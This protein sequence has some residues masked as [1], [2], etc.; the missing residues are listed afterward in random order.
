MKSSLQFHTY[1]DRLDG[2]PAAAIF[3]ALGVFTRLPFTSKLLYH[4]DSIN[5][6]LGMEH[7][8]VRL[9]QPH[10]PGYLLYVL[11]GRFLQIFFRDANTSLV[12]I[13]LIFSGLTVAVVYALAR[14]LFDLPTALIAGL[15][16][17]TS[18]AVW[19][20]G[21]VGLTYIL[22]TFF[23]T[24]IALACLQA[25]RG[26][27]RTVYVAAILLGLAGGIRQTTLVLMLPLLAFV[28]L[29]WGWRERILGA[30]ALGIAV[31]AWLI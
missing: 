17:L 21:E 3:F 30:L 8:D 2:W 29:R 25:L 6:A 10:P 23:V 12:V 4:W 7:Y 27:R 26:E 19:F 24:A 1:L 5:F 11:L 18:P 15:F 28:L 14:R 22:E 20:Y 31:L 16:T 9:H 13:S